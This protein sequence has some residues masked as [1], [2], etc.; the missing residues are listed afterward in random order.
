M[1]L[2]FPELM[3]TQPY[4]DGRWVQCGRSFAVNNPADGG[5]V[6]DVGDADVPLAES[7]LEAAAAAFPAWRDRT[8]ADRCRLLQRW[9][10]LIVEHQED[11]ALIITTEQGKPLA[12]AR[13]ELTN[14]WAFVEWFAEEGKRVYGE[15][16][17]APG[18]DR[19]I[20][21]IRQ[22]VGVVAALTPWNFPSSMI[23]RKAAPG[24]GKERAGRHVRCSPEAWQAPPA[25][26]NCRGQ[27]SAEAF[28]RPSAALM[29]QECAGCRL[30]LPIAACRPGTDI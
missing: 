18:T 15:T 26:G 16:I 12:E 4:V 20:V 25:P 14:A 23:T 6:A 24:P 22:P 2:Q 21:V 19:R 10:E 17:P 11:L 13:A 5:K 3:R 8:A 28:N 9:C 27:M 7:A 30:S 29:Q 1:N